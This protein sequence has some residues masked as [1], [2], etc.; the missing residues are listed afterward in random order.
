M[1]EKVFWP[2]TIKSHIKNNG[3]WSNLP[4]WIDFRLL[5]K[6]FQRIC[7]AMFSSFSRLSYFFDLPISKFVLKPFIFIQQKILEAR[8]SPPNSTFSPQL[9]PPTFSNF[10]VFRTY[11][12]QF[13]WAQ[14]FDS[15]F[16][17]F[18]YGFLIINYK[19]HVKNDDR[20]ICQIG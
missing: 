17:H 20:P 4:N 13:K 6:F 2:L 12:T 14:L 3:F 8:F 11:V 9:P 19:N 10:V 5:P 18:L 15:I 7:S 1:A 16:H